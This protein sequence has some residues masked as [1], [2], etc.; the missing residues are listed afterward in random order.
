MSRSA[1]YRAVV[2]CIYAGIGFA[3]TELLKVTAGDCSNSLTMSDVSGG[4]ACPVVY[5]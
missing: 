3:L 4:D 5:L 2:L 1:D